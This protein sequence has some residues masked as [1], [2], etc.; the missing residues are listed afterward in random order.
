LIEDR[1]HE[2]VNILAHPNLFE[3]SPTALRTRE[4]WDRFCHRLFHAYQEAA[5]GQ[6]EIRIIF[7]CT[8]ASPGNPT[9]IGCA[10]S[11]IPKGGGGKKLISGRL[12]ATRLK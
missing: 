7:I 10:G 12:G 6:V 2:I 4:R 9:I 3:M 1:Q 5:L 11:R 8:M